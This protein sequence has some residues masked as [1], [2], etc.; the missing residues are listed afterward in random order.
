MHW[1]RSVTH[2]LKHS[3]IYLL[4]QPEPKNWQM[5]DGTGQINEGF[6]QYIGKL[7]V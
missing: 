4:T 3:F 5:A 2:I 1:T 7:W 6:S